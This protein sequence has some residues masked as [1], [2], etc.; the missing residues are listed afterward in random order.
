MLGFPRAKW[1]ASR[2]AVAGG[3]SQTRRLLPQLKHCSR[4]E[5]QEILAWSPRAD[6]DGFFSWA[7]ER[8]LAESQFVNISDEIGMEF[9]RDH[10]L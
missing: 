4:P 5:L 1:T 6:K 10:E 3:D 7:F 2:G 9:A 8:S